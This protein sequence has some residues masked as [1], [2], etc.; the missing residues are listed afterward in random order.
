MEQLTEEKQKQIKKM[1]TAR[2]RQRLIK[3]GFTELG[4]EGLSCEELMNTL[5]DQMIKE[6]LSVNEEEKEAVGG[7][8]VKKPP[9]QTVESDP[10]PTF[11]NPSMSME[12]IMQLMMMLRQDE[13]RR[14]REEKKE[15][16][17]KEENGNLKRKKKRKNGDLKRKNGDLKRKKKRKKQER[18]LKNYVE[19][20]WRSRNSRLRC[21]W[22]NKRKTEKLQSGDILK[23][24]M[25]LKRHVN[26]R[27]KVK[28]RKKI[29]AKKKEEIK[30]RA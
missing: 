20:N 23:W 17:E 11:V 1:S 25:H 27:R 15:H 28:R 30:E 10:I 21:R 8:K 26:R 18:M 24:Q 14:R 16:E 19:K 3:A 29:K 2:F 4:L 7:A 13:E 22:S 6:E 9:E 12:D 5:A